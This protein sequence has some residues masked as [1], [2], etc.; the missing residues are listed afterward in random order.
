VPGGTP[1]SPYGGDLVVTTPG[2]VI[3][4]LDVG[5]TIYVNAP[6]VR[7]QRTR[8]RNGIGNNSSGLMIQDTD[9]GPDGGLASGWSSSGIGVGAANFTCLRCNIH[10]FPDGVRANGGVTIQ[11][12][13]IHDLG[14][15]DHNDGIQ[16]YLPGSAGN[17][18]IRHNFVDL[19]GGGRNGCIFYADDW[20]G[21]V[22]IDSNL[23]AGGNWSIRVHESGTAQVTNNVVIRNSYDVGPTNFQ[24]G[25]ITQLAGNTFDDGSPF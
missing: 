12:S 13:W 15:N 23:F 2:A 20:R 8:A 11:D 19:R 16:R 22:T 10:N 4:A 17:D 5:G 3:D 6:G 25:N 18:V 14:A 9:I 7:I 24:Y 1:L 21:N